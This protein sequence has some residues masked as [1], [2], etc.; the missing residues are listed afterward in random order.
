VFVL[1]LITVCFAAVCWTAVSTLPDAIAGAWTSREILV[2]YSWGGIETFFLVSSLILG[3]AASWSVERR[4]HAT[5]VHL[6]SAA[7][8]YAGISVA[9][10]FAG[11]VI[12]AP[13]LTPSLFRLFWYSLLPV[14]VSVAS[15]SWWVSAS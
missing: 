3:W 8:V 12:L 1:V 5:G 10:G 6:F 13:E 9:I 14:L 2:Y 7:A 15:R 11:S 4:F